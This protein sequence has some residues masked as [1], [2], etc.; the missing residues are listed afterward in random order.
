MSNRSPIYQYKIAA[1]YNVAAGSLINI[2]TIKPTNDA[3]FFAPSAL[4]HSAPGSRVGRL[5]GLGFRR[6]FPFVD[7]LMTLTLAQYEYLKTTYCS[8]GFS[9]FV[10]I[11]T[12]LGTST[13]YRCN[14][15]MDVPETEGNGEYYAFKN[16]RIRFTRLVA[17]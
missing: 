4:F 7:W 17:L 5:T 11:N 3:Y 13:Y 9:G 12:T 14:A 6:G 16:I 1:N 2:E 15:V 10:T 8:G